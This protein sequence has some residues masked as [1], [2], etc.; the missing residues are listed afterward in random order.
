MEISKYIKLS[1]SALH[2]LQCPKFHI[3]RFIH[4]KTLA[5]RLPFQSHS[6]KKETP[7]FK[8]SITLYELMTG[9]LIVKTT[10]NRCY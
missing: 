4:F 5:L 1:L 3:S 2:I 9:D 6:G 7:L 10:E 8:H